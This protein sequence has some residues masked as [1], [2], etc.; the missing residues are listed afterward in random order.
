MA[1]HNNNLY[2]L[3]PL[4]I[5]CPV[6][7]ATGLTVQGTAPNCLGNECSVC[8]GTGKIIICQSNEFRGLKTRNDVKTVTLSDGTIKS[9]EKWLETKRKF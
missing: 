7:K 5:N 8:T 3:V 6:C 9:Y 2:P 1:P 4:V